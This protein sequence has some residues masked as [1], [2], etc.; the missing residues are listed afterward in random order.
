MKFAMNGAL[1]LGHL[2]GANVEIRD[3]VA[4]EN[5]PLR[6]TVEEIAARG[7]RATGG[8]VMPPIPTSS[9]S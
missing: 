5:S 1:T 9:A 3:E 6:L 8:R 4:P 2:D 7:S